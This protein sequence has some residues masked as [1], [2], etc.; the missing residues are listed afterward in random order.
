M[1]GGAGGGGGARRISTAH[2][3]KVTTSGGA[4]MDGG[5]GRIRGVRQFC[6]GEMEAVQHSRGSFHPPHQPNVLAVSSNRH[7]SPCNRRRIS[8]AAVSPPAPSNIV[9]CCQ[10][11]C[12]PA[13]A[14]RHPAIATT[15]LLSHAHLTSLWAESHAHLTSPWAEVH[16]GVPVMGQ[17]T[18]RFCIDLW[19]ATRDCATASLRPDPHFKNFA[20]FRLSLGTLSISP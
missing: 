17:P 4:E 18:L 5:G 15:T 8:C 10:S 6:C 13:A 3:K 14:L 16:A 9:C 1:D 11:S 19:N 2:Q 7:P 12:D 20:L